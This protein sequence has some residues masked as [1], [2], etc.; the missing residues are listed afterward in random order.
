MAIISEQTYT[1]NGSQREFQVDGKILSDS[2][3]AVWLIDYTD[4]ENPVETRIPTAEYDVLGS[5]VLLDVAPANGI[6]VSL[7]LSD[8]GEGI[9]IPPSSLSTISA[10]ISAVLTVDTNIG[11]I[12]T[13]NDNITDVNTVATN[14]TDVNTNADNINQIKIVADT[15]NGGGSA[16]GGQYYG[17]GLTKPIG[18]VGNSTI[19][20]ETISI[21]AGTNAFAIDELVVENGTE[22]VLGKDSV[23]K[24]L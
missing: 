16:T 4:T 1:A 24:I 18:F 11:D 20:N 14:I 13:V 23:F 15:I 8:N 2:H 3:I 21:K 9:D 6:T 5:I 22:I 10:N 12:N 19:E 7:K 17:S